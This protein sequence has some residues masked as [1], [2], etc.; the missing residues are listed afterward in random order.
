MRQFAGVVGIAFGLLCFG[1][2]SESSRNTVAV[3]ACEEGETQP[4][5][6]AGCE[7]IATCSSEGKFADCECV[8]T[9]ASTSQGQGGTSSTTSTGDAGP[10]SGGT[11]NVGTGGDA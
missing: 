7:G 8:S 5:S 10:T 6:L 1:A 11:S 9:D 2:C 4:C 3:Q